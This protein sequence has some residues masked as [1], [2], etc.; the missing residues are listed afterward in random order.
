MNDKIMPAKL[1][2]KT[3]TGAFYALIMLYNFEIV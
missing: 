1:Q 2:K 3:A